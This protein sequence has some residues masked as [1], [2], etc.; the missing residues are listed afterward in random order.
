MDWQGLLFQ[1]P[2]SQP[3]YEGSKHHHHHPPKKIVKKGAGPKFVVRLKTGTAAAATLL[4]VSIWYFHMSPLCSRNCVC[5][6]CVDVVVVVGGG[7]FSPSGFS[8]RLLLF[9]FFFLPISLHFCRRRRH[10]YILS[11]WLAGWPVYVL[12][13]LLARRA[14]WAEHSVFQ[15]N[16]SGDDPSATPENYTT[17]RG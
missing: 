12:L 6:C 7:L 13:L 14:T 17:R 8:P 15:L 2:P 4:W 11:L 9:V 5:V 10:L 1:V 16:A 3:R